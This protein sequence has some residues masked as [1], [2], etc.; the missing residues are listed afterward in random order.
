MLFFGDF[1]GRK[2]LFKIVKHDIHI[3][4]IITLDVQSLL[5]VPIHP[6]YQTSRVRHQLKQPSVD[7]QNL[8]IFPSIP[9]VEQTKMIQKSLCG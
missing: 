9:S 3:G 2:F 6:G 4:Y 8:C 5:L 7:I 1:M